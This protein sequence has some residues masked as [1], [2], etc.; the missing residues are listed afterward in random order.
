MLPTDTGIAPPPRRAEAR[1]RIAAKC[2]AAIVA[3]ALP[4]DAADGAEWLRDA[5]DRLA[6][7]GASGALFVFIREPPDPR[8][9]DVLRTVTIARRL[10]PNVVATPA[11]LACRAQVELLER[12]GVRAMYLTAHDT[13]ATQRDSWRRALVWLTNAAKFL[14]KTRVGF[15]FG[16]TPETAPQLAGVLRLVGKLERSELLLWDGSA[17]DPDA[18]RVPPS[19]ALR[20]LDVAVTTAQ[21]L[22]IRIQTVGFERLR[23]AAAPNGTEPCAASRAMIELLREAIPLPS[24]GGGLLATRDAAIAIADT[25][26]TGPDLVQLAFELA[27]GG[28]PFVDL[29]PCLG[30][31]PPGEAA[32][33]AGGPGAKVEACRRCP[34]DQTCA[35]VPPPL[36]AMPGLRAAI[37]PPPHWM[38]IPERARIA[39]VCPIVV[40]GT[41]G[42]TFFSLARCLVRLGARVD[43]V[44]PWEIHADISASFTATQRIGEP[45]NHSAVTAFMI[46]APVEHYD[47]IITPDP[48]VTRPLVMSGRL[49]PHTRL[50]IT[51]FHMLGGID[52]WVRDLCAPGRRPEEGGWW[53]SN[54]VMLYSGFP[55][56]GRLYT[57]YGVPMHQVAWQ[58]YAVDPAHFAMERPATDGT[59]I[60]SAGHHRRDLDTFLSAAA[61]L[62]RDIHPIELFAPGAVDVPPQVRFRGTVRAEVFCP[63]VGHSRFM[64]VPLLDDPHNAA[65]IT[66]LVTAIVYGRPIVATA[67][68]AVRDYVV[69]GVNGLLVPPRDPQALADAIE[70]LDRD[71]ELLAALAD[72]ARAAA[73]MYTTEVW[74]RALVHGSRTFDAAHWMWTKWRHRARTAAGSHG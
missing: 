34:I 15:C 66:A 58:P 20:A 16:L 63:E 8:V 7:A 18:P 45:P 44:S 17:G 57:R 55:G 46:D 4:D 21:K 33:P 52:E 65:G 74:A 29:P 53:P 11:A 1:I 24:A 38:P 2:G 26:P 39:V 23:I 71:P 10:Q 72:G 62:G 59:T 25:A 28:R 31:P 68:A 14:V 40:E 5:I 54:Q 69:D 37:A 56:Y 36:L 12:A 70:R 64:V 73:P 27:G 67:T 13:G 48:K 35:G 49:R 41:Y 30:G 47:A 19:A 50:A 51:D 42:A 9:A 43:I 3:E 60:I 22:G 6:A 61:R 32:R